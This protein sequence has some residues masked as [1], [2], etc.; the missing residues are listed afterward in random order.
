MRYLKGIWLKFRE[1]YD[2]YMKC[3]Y[4]DYM[5]L[6]KDISIDMSSRYEVVKFIDLNEP[7][8]VPNSSLSYEENRLLFIPL[9][10]LILILI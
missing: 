2:Y 10:Y 8:L 4:G 7:Y 6:P 1:G 5:S 3:I 9:N